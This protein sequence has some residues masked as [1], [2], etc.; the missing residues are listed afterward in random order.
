MN[1][2]IRKLFH[3]KKEKQR[4]AT[5]VEF[6]I[7]ILLFI[8]I[9]FG[10]IEFGLLMYNQHIV[11]N[12][13]REGARYGIVSRLSEDRISV[14]EIQTKVSSYTDRYLVTFSEQTPNVTVPSDKCI[15]P[16]D[17]LSITVIYRYNFLFLRFLQRNIESTTTMRCE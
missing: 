3:I 13:A 14:S 5:A 7:V 1:I 10:I 11:T 15:E 8:S 16:G 12:A 17:L 6:A 4:G 9:I 2:L